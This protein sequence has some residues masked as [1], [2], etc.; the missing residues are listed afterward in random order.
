MDSTDPSTW[1]RHLSTRI[2]FTS[3]KL[4][5]AIDSLEGRDGIQSDKLEEWTH[6]NLMKFNKAKCTWVRATLGVN[7]GWVNEGI[8]SSPA[9]ENLRVL[10]DEKLDERQ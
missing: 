7:T 8:E 5:G 10:V 9:K 4:S 1:V 3:T 6:V 2:P